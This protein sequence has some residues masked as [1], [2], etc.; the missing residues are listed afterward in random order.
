MPLWLNAAILARP[1]T[2]SV[3]K[4]R[5]MFVLRL[6]K[7]SKT[8]HGTGTGTS[9]VAV[10]IVSIKTMKQNHRCKFL[11][12]MYCFPVKKRNR[13]CIKVVASPNTLNN[14]SPTS[15][16]PS[17]S[18]WR[19]ALIQRHLR[20]RPNE[21]S[22]IVQDTDIRWSFSQWNPKPFHPSVRQ[23]YDNPTKSMHPLLQF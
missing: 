4:S 21:L 14:R 20:Q 10:D 8:K 6:C 15:N 12:R 16:V 5:G 11:K 9:L 13:T 7:V 23:W 17:A 3:I 19:L 2:A 18:S 22:H 1:N